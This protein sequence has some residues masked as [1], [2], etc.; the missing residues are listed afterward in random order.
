MSKISFDLPVKLDELLEFSFNFNNLIKII[1]YLHQNNLSLS[2]ELKDM[3]KRLSAM[4]SLKND[5]DDLKIKSSNIEK[6]NDNLNRSFI[7]LQ[8][9][10]L[11]YDKSISDIQTKTDDFESQVKNFESI[12]SEHENNLNHLN[13]VVEE[14]VKATNR[15]ND[16]INTHIKNITK[17]REKYEEIEKKDK[18]EFENVNKNIKEINTNLEE[19]HKEIENINNNMGEMNETIK[20]MMNNFEKK[21]SDMNN[22]ILNIIN[23]IAEINNNIINIANNIDK[24]NNTS[25]NN[26]SNINYGKGKEVSVSITNAI[27]KDANSSNFFKIAMDEIEEEKNKFN[28]L[29]ED[30]ESYKETQKKDNTTINKNINNIKEEYYGLKN[31]VEENSENIE[32]LQNNFNEYINTQNEER[33]LMEENKKKNHNDRDIPITELGNKYVKMDVFKKLSDNVRILTSTMNS[34]T[35]REEMETQLKKLNQRLENVEMIQQGQTHGPKTRINL[36]LVNAPYSNIDSSNMSKDSEEQGE[37]NEIEYFTKK[38]EKKITGNIANVINKEIKN[39]DFELNPK[40]NEL[41]NTY[42]KNCEDIE[43]NNKTIIDIRNIL[44]SNPTKNDIMKL[45]KEIEQLEDAIRANKVKILELTKNI[46]GTEE[47][48][49]EDDNNS[50]LPGTI[51]GKIYFLNRT[52]Q[53]LNTKLVSLENKQKSVTKEVKDDI[54]QNLKTE[55]AKIMQQF[56]L[57]LESFTNKFEHELKNKIDQIGLSDFETKMN[58][59]FHIDLKEKLDKNDMKKNNNIIKRKIDSLENKISKTLVDTIIDLQMDDQ[60]LII[61]KNANGVDVCASCNQPFS[62]NNN[63]FMGG[64]FLSGN[65]NN[66][67]NMNLNMSRKNINRSLITYTQPSNIKSNNQTSERSLTLGNNKLPDIIPPIHPK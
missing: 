57:R 34:K 65:I 54:K 2:Q 51:K 29:K 4:E 8:E 42:K 66:M 53:T 26:I 50:G 9:K 15:F 12:Q 38:I 11:K 61:K 39:I 47:D 22:R 16:S 25:N 31:I 36:G 41:F 5:I 13:K 62:R 37:L 24:N 40:I 45:Q 55:T 67:S 1:T 58:N 35:G 19:E 64:E 52:C 14:N 59:K 7:N 21:N 20:N 33:E 10:I 49:E 44:V 18:E 30:F 32:N 17:I 46:E 56:K 43:K 27:N 60:P 28:K 23:D 6:T 48:D 63:N 3:D